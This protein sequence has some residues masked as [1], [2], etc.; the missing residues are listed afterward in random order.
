MKI[1]YNSKNLLIVLLITYIVFDI[2]SPEFIRQFLHLFW[3]TTC[4]YCCR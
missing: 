3:K 4:L 1:K 2:K